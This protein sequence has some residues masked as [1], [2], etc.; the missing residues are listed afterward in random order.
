MVINLLILLTLT[1]RRDKQAEPQWIRPR[2]H[3]AVPG[4]NPNRIIYVF[5]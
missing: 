4:S 3:H 5:K 2:Y 1:I